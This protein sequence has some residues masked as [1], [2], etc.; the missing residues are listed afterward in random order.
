MRFHG[1]RWI[2]RIGNSTVAV[3]NA[4]SW[5]MWGQE[6][7]IV[8]GETVKQAQGWFVTSRTFAEPWLSLDGE[9]EIRVQIMAGV[10]S[11]TCETF[12]NGE[13]LSPQACYAV[14]WNGERCQWP[15]EALWEARPTRDSIGF[16]QPK[17]LKAQAKG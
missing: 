3:D 10:L 9:T 16:S 13:R 8:N 1:Q 11:L 6:R 12:L 2:Y 5:S 17:V 15:D 7:M 4:F 14:H